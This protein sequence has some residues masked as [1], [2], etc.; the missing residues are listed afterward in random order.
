MR[1]AVR[2]GQRRRKVIID[3]NVERY[4]DIRLIG[5]ARRAVLLASLRAQYIALVRAFFDL[6]PDATPVRR[7][8]DVPLHELLQ[9]EALRGVVGLLLAHAHEQIF[10]FL[11]RQPRFD[12]LDAHEPLF[13]EHLQAA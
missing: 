1:E 13:V 8:R 5:F 6:A 3:V 7:Q 11:S 12:T 2:F 4:V 9:P 10:E